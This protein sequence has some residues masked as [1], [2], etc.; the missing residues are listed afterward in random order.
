MKRKN[1]LIP[2]AI[3]LLVLIIIILV[4]GKKA[5]WMGSDISVSVLVQ[6]AESRTITEQITANGKIQPKTEV[7]ISPDVS[8]EIIELYVEEGNQ[9]K[10][11]D[12][13]M[14]IKPDLYISA[15]NRAEAALNSAK[16]RQAQAEAQLIERQLA[17]RRAEQ[18]YRTQTI[19]QSDFETAQ[20]GF[21]IAEAEVKAA[22]FSV[23]SA[24]ASVAEAR[25]QLTKTRVFAP[26]AGTISRLNVE[27][28]E[29]VV[30]TNM[31]AGTETMVIADL[32]KMEVRVD[33]N[34]NDIVK[35]SNG[36]TALVQVDAYLN[37]KFKGVVTEIANSARVTGA[38]TDQ[39]TNFE[40]KILLLQSSYHDLIDT[41]RQQFHPFRPGMSATVDILTK[42]RN[43]VVAVP[44]QAVSTRVVERKKDEQASATIIAGQDEKEEVVF[45][46]ADGR[47]RK[48]PV[49]S[50]IQDKNYIEINEGIA[51]GDEIVTGPFNVVSRTLNDSML[52]KIV[53]E[54]ELFKAPGK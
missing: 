22:Q 9:V 6:K 11:G 15:L 54:A 52:V 24:E 44:V 37:R 46:I 45:R 17:F 25:E 47:A 32:D 7:K 27:K 13:L 34:E 50:G 48:V 29:R 18:L 16:A 53:T 20:A 41:V 2:L 39:V 35:V 10:P 33:V 43:N 5:G 21:S 8:G 40:V 12:P 19:P 14:V 23:K 4:V 26:I 51:A 36:D 42:T 28:G 30:G 38:T 49:K 3:V 1:K 31:Y